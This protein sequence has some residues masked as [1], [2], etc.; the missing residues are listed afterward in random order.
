VDPATSQDP[1]D[2]ARAPGEIKLDA[3]YLPLYP[4]IDRWSPGAVWALLAGSFLLLFVLPW[5]PPRAR[6]A[7]AVVNLAYCNG[8]ARCA[9]D[10]P[11][12]AITMSSRSDGLPFETEAVVNTDVCVGCGICV[13]A[14]PPST[15]FR[16]MPHLATGIDLPNPSLQDLRDMTRAA[17]ARIAERPRLLVFGCRNG[18]GAA[19]LDGRRM[20]Y[21]ALP[22]V[23][24]LP[25]SFI[26]Y[27]LS[28]D[29]SEGVL[30]TGCYE[31]CCEQRLGQR[32]TE[33][34]LAGT[35][36]PR[37]RARVPH[38]RVRLHWPSHGRLGELHDIA[39]RFV[40]DLEHLPAEPGEAPT[41]RAAARVRVAP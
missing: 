1:A 26:D 33:Q 13:G 30:L 21:V 2:L 25:P 41:E 12:A 24:M 35:R 9:D 22:C 19:S 20:A 23:A 34:R 5:L 8:C 15:P 40:A 17:S 27:A 10:C 38:E 16:S 14:C 3:F 6:P 7:P 32:W 39:I 4:L 11:Y 36:D 18:P 28:R 31:G 29:L 37:L